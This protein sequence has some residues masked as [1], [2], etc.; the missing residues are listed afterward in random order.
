MDA[1]SMTTTAQPRVQHVYD[2]AQ[3]DRVPDAPTSAQVT[4]RRYV[5][6]ATLATAKSSTVGAALTGRHLI[7]GL[8]RMERGTGSKAHTH[9]NEQ[10]NYILQGT[11]TWEVGK[12]T[13]FARRGELMH[14]PAQAVHTGLACPDEDLMWFAMKDTRHGLA[15]PPVDGKYDGPAYLPGF[16]K[17]A[18]EP[19]KSTAELIAES[20]RDTAG[21]K[22]RYIYDFA[23]LDDR[24]PG[25]VSSVAVTRQMIA[26]DAGASGSLVTGEM[27]H[28]ARLAYPRGGTGCVHAHPNE[29][30]TF[31]LEGALRVEIDGEEFVVGRHGVVHVPPEA[32]HRLAA[33]GDDTVVITL[34]NSQH[35]FAA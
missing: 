10:F 33:A 14:T 7:V 35:P 12:E 22:T 31:V 28:I 21:E 30:F 2:F 34:Q 5:S 13:V 11:M 19:R 6:G 23:Q 8:M 20:G 17:R 1:T 32:P 29:Q 18:G 25:R 24:K 4:A 27:L 3:L 26:A 16:G 15:G 9:P